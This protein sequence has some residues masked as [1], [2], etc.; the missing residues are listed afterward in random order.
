MRSTIHLLGRAWR[1]ISSISSVKDASPARLFF[2]LLLAWALTAVAWGDIQVKPQLEPYEPC[3]ATVT[4]TDVPE[5]AKLRGSFAV[6]DGSYLP[7]G[8]NTFH[9]WLPPGKHV[10][11]ANGVWVLT[12]DI[13]VGGQTVPV[14][15]DFGQY[16]YE[17]TITV[18]P[19]VP[20]PV[21]F[22]PPGPRRLVILEETAQRTPAFA[23][24]RQ[25]LLKEFPPDQLQILDDD[26]P[27]ASKY[28]SQLPADLRPALL[29]LEGDRLLRAV[30]CPPSVGGVK[31][32][33][34]K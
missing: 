7:A 15:L 30:A 24:L 14:L 34:A 18:G 29:I 8:E 11:K 5:G 19:E 4:I 31:E 1:R 2:Y 26:L 23:V 32:E 27:A 20:T 6:S 13:D 16:S 3:V 21:P 28:L 9:L 33:V 12:K 10:L 17:R 22:P 25:Q